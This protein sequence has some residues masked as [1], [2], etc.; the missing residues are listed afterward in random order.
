MQFISKCICLCHVDHDVD[1]Q[2]GEDAEDDKGALVFPMF[3]LPIFR[4]RAPLGYIHSA[5]HSFVFVIVFVF[6]FVSILQI[7][8]SNLP[9]FGKIIARLFQ[10]PIFVIY[11]ARL[12]QSD[13]IWQYYSQTFPI[14]NICHLYFTRFWQRQDLSV[15]FY[16]ILLETRF[17][18]DK[19]RQ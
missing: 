11:I 2:G 10:S 6:V 13:T 18:S 3:S 14:A 17:G 4:F 8:F 15:S 5:P 1:H 19:Y 16:Q 9:L 12:F 7:D